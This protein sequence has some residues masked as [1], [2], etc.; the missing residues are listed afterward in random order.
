MNLVRQKCSHACD[1]FCYNLFSLRPI[2]HVTN[3][4]HNARF[5][6]NS[7]LFAGHSKWANI[8]HIKAEKDGQ[9]AVTFTR[10][11]RQIR[12][13]IQEGNSSNP[14]TNT[15]LKN[16]I[17]FALKKN[18]PL[19]TIQNTIKKIEASKTQIK[20]H[21]L[22]IKALNKVYMICVLYTDN[23]ATLKINLAPILKKGRACYSECRHL[24]EDMGLIQAI[25]HNEIKNKSSVEEIFT[26]DAIDVGAEEV[27]I[28]DKENGVVNFLCSPIELNKVSK[29]LSAKGYKIEIAEHVFLPLSTVNIISEDL[30]SYKVLKDKILTIEG[31]ERIYDNLDPDIDS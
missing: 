11:S 26:E 14:A 20:E 19:S 31:L 18:M 5:H 8:K 9:R 7:Q 13:A 17:E 15:A 12:M 1:L 25:A 10:M 6:R 4:T 27:E 21:V 16:A 28:I 3:Y 29:S 24:F 2:F 22:E 30:K 23:L